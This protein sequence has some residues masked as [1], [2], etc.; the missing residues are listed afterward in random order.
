VELDM[1]EDA[2]PVKLGI[3]DGDIL[4]F[5]LQTG[6]DR[7]AKFT[8]NWPSLDDEVEEAEDADDVED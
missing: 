5:D 2:S 4:A 7:D 8:V 1:D 6:E 3:K